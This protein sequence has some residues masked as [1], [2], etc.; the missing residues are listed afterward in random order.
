M[1]LFW[2]QQGPFGND[3]IC[4]GSFCNFQARYANFMESKE[5]ERKFSDLFVRV[6]W[7]QELKCNST[8]IN[9]V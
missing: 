5:F 3:F 8:K 1:E 7:L 6:L 4:E 2:I 9:D